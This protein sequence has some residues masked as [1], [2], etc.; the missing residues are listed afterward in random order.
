MD[1]RG[2]EFAMR[3]KLGK[4]MQDANAATYAPL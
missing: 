2:L 4:L 1:A 3:S